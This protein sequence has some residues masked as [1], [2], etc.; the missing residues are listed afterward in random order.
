M[1]ITVML[2]CIQM[3][4]VHCYPPSAV[5]QHW[6]ALTAS[7]GSAECSRGTIVARLNMLRAAYVG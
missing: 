6:W 1:C 4:D 3:V 7:A 2:H 5:P